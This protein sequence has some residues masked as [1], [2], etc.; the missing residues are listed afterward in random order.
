MQFHTLQSL[1]LW[2]WIVL[3]AEP[4]IYYLILKAFSIT[5]TNFVVSRA[6]SFTKQTYDQT[7][8]TTPTDVRTPTDDW[9]PTNQNKS[10]EH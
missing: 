7:K 3:P 2:P 1:Q 4:L 9:R 5:A 10:S 6:S 8:R